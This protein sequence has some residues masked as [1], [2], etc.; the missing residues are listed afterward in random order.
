MSEIDSC[1]LRL[2][3]VTLKSGRMAVEARLASRDDSAEKTLLRIKPE[4]FGIRKELS[5]EPPNDDQ[6]KLPDTFVAALA[7][8]V[9]SAHEPDVVWLQLVEPFGYLALVPWESLILEHVGVPVVR[10]PS[11]T[12]TR[13]RPTNSLQIAV[14]AAVPSEQRSSE[15]RTKARGRRKAATSIIPTHAQT[16][17]DYDSSRH[18]AEFSAEDVDRVVRAAVEGSPRKKI[19]VHVV[20]TPW[21]YYDLRSLWRNRDWGESHQIHLHDPY[22]L[23]AEVHRTTPDEAAAQVP[24]LRLLKIAQ[25][26]QQADVV[27]VMC[28]ASVTDLK[29]RLVLADPMNG[30]RNVSSRYV[31]LPALMSTLDELGAWSLCLTSPALAEMAPQMRYIACRLAELRPGPILVT[32][33]QT[34]PTCDEIRQGYGFLFSRKP[35]RPPRMN[36]G[37][38]SCE[39]HRVVATLPRTVASTF[40]VNVP[41]AEEPH[42]QVA[43]VIADDDTPMWLAAAQ[44]FI[45][46][47]QLDLARIEGDLNEGNPSPEVVALA[48]GMRKALVIIQKVVAEQVKKGTADA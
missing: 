18:P 32:D 8:T 24:W 27:H 21:I 2:T 6:F 44:R 12:L 43:D 7:D 11:L 20:T 33:L 31:S 36:H 39:P 3:L 40:Q 4:E 41:T 10:L 13:R 22:E 29:A 15:W 23:R 48:K 46:Q 34:D 9:Q 14:L 25:G 35:S 37:M 30:S 28:H 5:D 26:G 16:P 1:L 42:G 47:R 17:G 38:V 19:T 45:E